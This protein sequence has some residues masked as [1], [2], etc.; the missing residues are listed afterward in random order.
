MHMHMC[1]SVYMCT[2]YVYVSVYTCVYV[3]VYVYVCACMWPC[4]HALTRKW[5]RCQM[6]RANRKWL[7]AHAP[8]ANT[9]RLSESKDNQFCHQPSSYSHSP[10]PIRYARFFFLTQKIVCSNV[11]TRFG[12]LLS[13]RTQLTNGNSKLFSLSIDWTHR[14]LPGKVF[15]AF[16]LLNSTISTWKAS[17]RLADFNSRN[18]TRTHARGTQRALYLRCT[19]SELSKRLHRLHYPSRIDFLCWYYC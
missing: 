10:S 16:I 1:T 15:A 17:T 8:W 7:L 11:S 14:A 4:A 6:H 13:R 19:W 3:Y 2:V 18:V 12:L 5:S 9:K